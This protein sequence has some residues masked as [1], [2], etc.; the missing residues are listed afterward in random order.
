MFNAYCLC[1]RSKP[2]LV[3]YNISFCLMRRNVK[4]SDNDDVIIHLMLCFAARATVLLVVVWLKL[5]KNSGSLQLFYGICINSDYYIV[6]HLSTVWNQFVA[7]FRSSNYGIVNL[8]IRCR[9]EMLMF[10]L[11]LCSA[12]FYRLIFLEKSIFRSLAQ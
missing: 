3:F 6:E 2:V 4:D 5:C 12:L 1:T 11:Q 10:Q 9:L 7:S 8:C